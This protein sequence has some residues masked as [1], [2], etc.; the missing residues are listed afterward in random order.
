MHYMCSLSVINIEPSIMCKMIP[1][2]LKYTVCCRFLPAR[3]QVV[4]AVSSPS[5]SCFPALVGFVYE[6]STKKV[7]KRQNISHSRDI[8]VSGCSAVHQ[9]LQK[10]LMAFVL[11]T[12]RAAE[13]VK[14]SHCGQRCQ[15]NKTEAEKQPAMLLFPAK[16]QKDDRKQMPWRKSKDRVG[17]V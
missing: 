8:Y 6:K 17:S 7:C 13:A 10:Y 15:K 2:M 14:P 16:Q 5:S 1:V 3:S 4:F 12:V 9:A 11:K